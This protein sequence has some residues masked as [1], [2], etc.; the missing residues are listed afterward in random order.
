MQIKDGLTFNQICNLPTSTRA[1]T[2][3]DRVNK[4]LC[5][6]DNGRK[7]FLGGGYDSSTWTLNLDSDSMQWIQRADFP[8]KGFFITSCG[9]ATK[10]NGEEEIMF[11]YLSV[12]NSYIFNLQNNAWRKGT[13]F[14]GLN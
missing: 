5:L 11:C 10:S 4:T 9:V 7:V 2:K 13:P 3:L 1:G 14:P 12:A 8:E 6:F